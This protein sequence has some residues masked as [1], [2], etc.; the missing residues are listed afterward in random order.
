MNEKGAVHRGE[1]QE[2]RSARPSPSKNS[3]QAAVAQHEARPNQSR[4]LVLEAGTQVRVRTTS[5]ISTKTAV[6]GQVFAATLAEPI[7]VDGLVVAERG[8]NVEGRVLTADKGGRVSGK[9]T[10]SVELTRIHLA[11]GTAAAVD[12]GSF[13]EAA[14]STKK[15]DATKV[16]IGAGLGAAIGAIAG[17]GRGAAIG[18]AAGGAAGGGMVL[19]TRGDDAVIPAESILTFTL[20]A[21]V[22]LTR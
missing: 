6:D 17:G 16:G 15:K 5:T 2:S 12:T 21:P 4:Q 1:A 9:A 13:V 18:A 22:T 10:L 14:S 11:N 7:V 20:K 19:A 3:A 8:A